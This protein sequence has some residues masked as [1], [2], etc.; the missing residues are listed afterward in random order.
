VPTAFS[1][2]NLQNHYK[3]L[4]LNHPKRICSFHKMWGNS[5]NR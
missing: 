2:V 4:E 5:S 1:E 3:I